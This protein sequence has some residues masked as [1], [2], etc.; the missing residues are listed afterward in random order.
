[1]EA[2]NLTSSSIGVDP[3]TSMDDSGEEEP[4]SS[5]AYNSNHQ[6]LLAE[7]ALDLAEPGPAPRAYYSKY[8]ILNISASK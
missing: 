3:T 1:L 7:N 6:M 2:T 8:H 4:T 5:R